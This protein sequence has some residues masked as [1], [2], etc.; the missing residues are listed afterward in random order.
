MLPLELQPLVLGLAA[1]RPASLLLLL[2]ITTQASAE[3]DVNAGRSREAKALGDL[4][5]VQLVHIK[6]RAERMRGVRLQ[7]RPV[8]FFR[9][10]GQK[11]AHEMFDGVVWDEKRACILPC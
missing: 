2:L 5:E 7:V 10:L 8:S 11:S 9:G 3:L 1:I 6:H 4:D